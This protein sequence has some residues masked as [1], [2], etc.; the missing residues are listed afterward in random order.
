MKKVLS[1]LVVLIISLLCTIILI[2]G[3]YLMEKNGSSINPSTD[4]HQPKSINFSDSSKDLL[5]VKDLA[6]I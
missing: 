5:A 3:N 6:E 2:V 1:H 4:N